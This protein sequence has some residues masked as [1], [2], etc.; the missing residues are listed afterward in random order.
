MISWCL[1][2]DLP[3]KVVS[4]VDFED[5]CVHFDI[6]R[7]RPYFLY[8]NSTFFWVVSMTL[9][10]FDSK[11]R[12]FISAFVVEFFFNKRLLHNRPPEYMIMSS[13]VWSDPE[14]G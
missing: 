7:F 11:S 6:V 8:P 2:F 1:N 5:L 3:H 9:F 4:D 14:S 13:V 10:F 12:V